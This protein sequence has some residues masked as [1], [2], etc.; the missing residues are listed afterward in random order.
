MNGI[1]AWESAASNHSTLFAFDKMMN[2]IAKITAACCAVAFVQLLYADAEIIRTY[3]VCDSITLFA[4]AVFHCAKNLLC[5]RLLVSTQN[6]DSRLQ[7]IQP[8]V[9]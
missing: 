5:S 3:D 6:D 4:A 7:I 8:N 9:S 2:D 1:K